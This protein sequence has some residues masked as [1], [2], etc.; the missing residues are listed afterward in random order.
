MQAF[1]FELQLTWTNPAHAY[2]SFTIG[3]SIR[4]VSF[5][6][7]GEVADHFVGAVVDSAINSDKSRVRSFSSSARDLTTASIIVMQNGHPTANVSGF[8]TAI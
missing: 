7:S 5:N 4:T 8:A 6:G 3:S 2:N 1:R